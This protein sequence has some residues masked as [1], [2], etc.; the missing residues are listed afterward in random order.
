MKWLQNLLGGGQPKFRYPDTYSEVI[1]E[2]DY[3]VFVQQFQA[4]VAALGLRA[5]PLA[6]GEGATVH[7]AGKTDDHSI[8]Y[9]HNVI[10]AWTLEAAENRA[11]V[12]QKFVSNLMHSDDNW[13]DLPYDDIKSKLC[14]RIYDHNPMLERMVIKPFYAG[15]KVL[16][17]DLGPSFATVKQ[18]L[19]PTWGVPEAEVWAQAHQNMAEQ[20]QLAEARDNT[21]KALFYSITA[22]YFAPALLEHV[23]EKHPEMKGE[24]GMLICMPHFDLVTVIPFHAD[25]DAVQVVNMLSEMHQVEYDASATPFLQVVVWDKLDGTWAYLDA[26][27]GLNR[28]PIHSLPAAAA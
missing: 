16:A 10:R 23:L 20:L 1:S 19:L 5:K 27:Y 13:S 15:L 8:V 21:G 4:V 25:D 22:Q 17:I 7:Q 12:V 6:N 26:E 14:C 3:G 11:A 9:F 2:A 24:K 18:E 28:V